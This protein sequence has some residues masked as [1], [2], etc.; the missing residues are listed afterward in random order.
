MPV[1]TYRTNP[2]EW[3]L[4]GPNGKKTRFDSSARL[5]SNNGIA[6]VQAA[7]KASASWC[8]RP[9]KSSRNWGKESS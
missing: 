4:L 2:G 8:R 9:S 5:Y 3:K 6:L 1:Y 7:L